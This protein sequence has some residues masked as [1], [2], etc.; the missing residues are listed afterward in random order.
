MEVS[1]LSNRQGFDIND[2][3]CTKGLHKAIEEYGLFFSRGGHF[4][5]SG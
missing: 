2:S 3:D 4:D 1:N 5:S